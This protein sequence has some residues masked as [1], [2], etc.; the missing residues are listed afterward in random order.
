MT[1]AEL[2]T[3][4]STGTPTSSHRANRVLVRTQEQSQWWMAYRM[5]MATL[6]MILNA[7]AIMPVDGCTEGTS[8]AAPPYVHCAASAGTTAP[9]K[10]KAPQ[11]P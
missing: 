8:E 1:L 10:G 9:R 11:T 2:K 6:K 7:A 3:R 5:A 4:E